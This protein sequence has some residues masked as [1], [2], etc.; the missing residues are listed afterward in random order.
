MSLLFVRK[1]C[2]NTSHHT[3]R[4]QKS[5]CICVLLCVVFVI[6]GVSGMSYTT[7]R[8]DVSF[9]R[10]QE[11]KCLCDL[12]NSAGIFFSVD[13]HIFQD[14]SIGQMRKK[15][16]KDFHGLGG[17]PCCNKCTFN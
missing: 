11:G 17:S 3:L 7:R 6:C 4:A 14:R 5:Q 15:K 12:F 1:N 13:L 2:C 9:A 16:I 8:C 10:L